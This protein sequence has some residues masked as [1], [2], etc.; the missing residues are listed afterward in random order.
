VLFNPTATVITSIKPN[1]VAAFHSTT[2][3]ATISS[4][5]TPNGNPGGS[6]K[7]TTPIGWLGTAD[8]QNHTASLTVNAGPAG[9]YAVTASY[10]GDPAYSPSASAVTDLTVTPEPSTVTL[11]SDHNPAIVNTPVTFKAVVAAQSPGDSLT[12]TITFLDGSTPLG[13]PVV[14]TNGTASLTT[15]ALALGTHD[16]TA[17]YSGDANLQPSTSAVLRQS[18]VAY[19]GDFD[20]SAKP[21][22]GTIYTGEAAQFTLAATAK[23]G[24]DLALDLSCDGLPQE[25][26]C[27][28]KPATLAKGSG[29]SVLV[30]KTSAPHKDSTAV[31]TPA[32]VAV[33]AGIFGFFLPRR[34]R[35]LWSLML[36]LLAAVLPGCGAPSQISGG[37]PPGVYTI[38]VKA[39][40]AAA[41]GPQLSHS[42]NLKL[43]VNSLF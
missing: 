19:T 31:A 35:L 11:T 40:T 8:V 43:T 39:H 17:S 6:V 27:T 20:L 26:T 12:G 25:T 42:I 30:V 29:Q 24:F 22:A 4:S 21:G 13:K 2:L 33:L 18:I 36:V 3:V 14:I 16:I 34:R 37:T 5:T 9:T 7:F 38:T 1:P 23:N 32:S 28:F 15:S 10:S 41:A